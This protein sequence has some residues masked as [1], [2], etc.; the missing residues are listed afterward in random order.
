MFVFGKSC[1][2][3]RSNQFKCFVLGL[4]QI[5]CRLYKSPLG[6]TINQGPP[7]V[8]TCKNITYAR[9]RS[10]SPCQS[11]V[12]H[13]NTQTTQHTLKVSEPSQY[14]S[15]SWKHQ[16]N[17]HT[18]KASEPSQCFSGLWKHP[19]NSAYTKS[20]RAFTV[21]QCIMETPKQPSMH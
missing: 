14:F 19:N 5:L 15:V 11:S 1:H 9:Q 3:R 10:C 20:V 12:Y 4:S 6:E 7:C 8:Y 16:S 18:L 2:V 17:H 13:G 21:F